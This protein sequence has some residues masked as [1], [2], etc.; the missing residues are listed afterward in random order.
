M[1]VR[2]VEV[3]GVL[4]SDEKRRAIMEMTP[5]EAFALGY[6]EGHHAGQ[7]AE[8]AWHTEAQLEAHR[9]GEAQAKMRETHRQAAAEYGRLLRRRR[10]EFFWWWPRSA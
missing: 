8:V 2:R 1:S 4:L 9:R 5:E 6:S 7:S 10:G 3:A